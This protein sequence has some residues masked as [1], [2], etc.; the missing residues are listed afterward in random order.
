M[1]SIQT[2]MLVWTLWIHH[3]PNPNPY[4]K[5]NPTPTGGCGGGLI[6]SCTMLFSH[7]DCRLIRPPRSGPRSGGPLHIPD[8]APGT[9]LF[10]SWTQAR[11]PEV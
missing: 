6:M 11:V 1:S 5:P 3:A 7:F 9:D 8:P 2:S 4:P 10:R